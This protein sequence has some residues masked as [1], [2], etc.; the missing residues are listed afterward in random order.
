MFAS[1]PHLIKIERFFGTL[2]TI[3]ILYAIAI[4]KYFKEFFAGLG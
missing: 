3:G 1:A 4:T 2:D